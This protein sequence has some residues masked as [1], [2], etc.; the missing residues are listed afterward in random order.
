VF[1][2]LLGFF[3]VKSHN[4]DPDKDILERTGFNVSARH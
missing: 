1:S 3:E 2:T 4:Y